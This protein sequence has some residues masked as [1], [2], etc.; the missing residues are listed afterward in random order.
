VTGLSTIKSLTKRKMHESVK[1]VA[2]I[3]PSENMSTA[4]SKV[5]AQSKYN[6]LYLESR[7][8]LD[9]NRTRFENEIK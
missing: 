9:A 7:K 5:A 4:R 8:L 1:K 6:P 2:K 3:P